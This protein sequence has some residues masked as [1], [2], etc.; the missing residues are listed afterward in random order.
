M[1]PKTILGKLL[2]GRR[3]ELAKTQ[4]NLERQSKI[5]LVKFLSL[6][7]TGYRKRIPDEYIEEIARLY[8]IDP[9]KISTLDATGRRTFSAMAVENSWR[10]CSPHSMSEEKLM[11]TT[12]STSNLYY[13]LRIGKMMPDDI[14]RDTAVRIA[15]LV[16]M[17]CES[18]KEPTDGELGELLVIA[19]KIAERENRLTTT[20]SQQSVPTQ[21]TK[22]K[23]EYGT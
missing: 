14:K 13:I 3:Q 23:E 22:T 21:E 6:L 1:E 9:N 5:P 12:H 20:S 8:E 18:F 7:E 15:R 17:W 19:N 11:S 10:K 2:R 4:K 16:S